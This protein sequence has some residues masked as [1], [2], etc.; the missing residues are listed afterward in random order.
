MEIRIRLPGLSVSSDRSLAPLMAAAAVDD[1]YELV[2]PS[3]PPANASDP[4]ASDPNCRFIQIL[5][6]A[7][8]SKWRQYL[9]EGVYVLYPV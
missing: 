6:E 7:D 2:T 8:G 9:C 3:S 1:A 5:T 4:C